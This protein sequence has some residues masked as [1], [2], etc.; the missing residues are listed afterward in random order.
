[1]YHILFD[2][3]IAKLH[4]SLNFLSKPIENS[5]REIS[6]ILTIKTLLLV[7]PFKLKPIT[8]SYKTHLTPAE[9]LKI[10]EAQILK[11]ETSVVLF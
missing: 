11:H 8:A 1:M 3:F 10:K 7:H 6:N 2:H 4:S 9:S 5:P